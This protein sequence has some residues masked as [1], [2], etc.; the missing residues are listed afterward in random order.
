MEK[1]VNLQS[2]SRQLHRLVRPSPASLVE[3]P[4]L[5][6]HVHLPKVATAWLV[7]SRFKVS[8]YD[9]ERVGYVIRSKRIMIRIHGG[10]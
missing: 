9:P 4:T 6:A 7:K 2:A 8:Q 10:V 3:W 5:P 1:L